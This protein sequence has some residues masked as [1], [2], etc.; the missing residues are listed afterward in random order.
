M[1][2]L[3]KPRDGTAGPIAIIV[4]LVAVATLL[5]I[6]VPLLGKRVIEKFEAENFATAVMAQNKEA[7]EKLARM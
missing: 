3:S 1:S 4:F 2:I 7:F 5:V 6:L